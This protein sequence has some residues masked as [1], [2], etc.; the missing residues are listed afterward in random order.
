MCASTGLTACRDAMKITTLHMLVFALVA[1]T[2]IIYS[3]WEL[4]E[5]FTGGKVGG[6]AATSHSWTSHPIAAKPA[7]DLSPTQ[8]AP[9]FL[10]PPR[11]P[12]QAGGGDQAVESSSSNAPK[13]HSGET[14]GSDDSNGRASG[15]SKHSGAANSAVESSASTGSGA[16]QANQ[17]LRNISYWRQPPQ[18]DLSFLRSLFPP[19]HDKFIFY[20]IDPGGAS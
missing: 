19:E 11:P 10:P 8:R 13:D 9:D 16:D 20:E 3:Q 7:A 5:L 4:N 6:S 18:L 12:Q 14:S 17:V 2:V 15:S 1:A